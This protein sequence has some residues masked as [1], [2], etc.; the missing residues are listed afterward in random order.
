LF[1]TSN[2]AEISGQV[3]D[4]DTGLP[5]PGVNIVIEGTA[6]IAASDKN[7][8]FKLSGLEKGQHRITLRYMF[9]RS[10]KDTIEVNENSVIHKNYKLELNKILLDPVPKFENY[11]SKIEQLAKTQNILTLKLKN[12][13]L[14]NG[15]VFFRCTL[16]NE[17]SLPINILLTSEC[18]RPLVSIIS[19]SNGEIIKKNCVDLSCDTP[20]RMYPDS[21]DMITLKPLE[22]F[23]YPVTEAYLYNF[24]H[25]PKDV[26]HIKLKYK[27]KKPEYILPQMDIREDL[28]QCIQVLN[29]LLRGEFVSVNSLKFKNK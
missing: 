6:K 19:N 1:S 2:G 8:N 10:C 28:N 4:S 14:L 18:W 25:L 15:T 22:S 17:S 3:T 20:T 29:I 5:L 26:Y 21:S 9:Y 27:F 13:E 16:R 11:H 7:G 24:S 23:E 12:V